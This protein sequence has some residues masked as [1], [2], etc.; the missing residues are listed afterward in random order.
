MATVPVRVPVTKPLLR[1]G[2]PK[3]LPPD[4]RAYETFRVTQKFGSL[5]GFFQGQAHGAVDIGNFRCGDPAIAPITG[6]LRRTKDGA[7]ALGVVIQSTVEPSVSWELWHLNGY[8][9]P[10][11]GLVTAGTQIGV[12]GRT[13]LGDVCHMHIEYKLNG[14]KQDPE[15]YLFG[16]PLVIGEDEMISC[17]PVR[18]QWDIPAGTQFY[19]DGP[20]QGQPKV[21]S[22]AER[23]WSNGETEDGLWRRVEY[24]P[25]EL[26][27]R[28]ADL[29]PRAGTRNPATGYGSASMGSTEAQV[30]TR[31]RAAAD[32][33]LEPAKAAASRYGAS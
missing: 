16:T 20:E 28:R 32:A 4:P 25:E 23:R 5:D 6:L 19:T 9:G 26:W 7:G 13:G 24:G 10:S 1:M 33:V 8:A 3:P 17:H 22:T 30:K 18:E 15:P 11:S 31:E 12:V 27:I 14:V 2:T 21:F 29:V